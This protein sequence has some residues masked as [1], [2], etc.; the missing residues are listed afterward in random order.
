M[1]G[2]SESL[3]KRVV[4]IFTGFKLIETLY[5]LPTLPTAKYYKMISG[6]VPKVITNNQITGFKLLQPNISVLHVIE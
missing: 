3:I 4:Q 6:Q 5:R 2:L 1:H